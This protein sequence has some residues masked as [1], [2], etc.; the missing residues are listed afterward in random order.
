LLIFYAL[1]LMKRRALVWRASSRN[2]VRRELL[3]LP[4]IVL[5]VLISPGN[6]GAHALCQPLRDFALNALQRSGTARALRMFGRGGACLQTRK[7][8]SRTSLPMVSIHMS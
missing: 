3:L 7:H 4:A 5:N 6:Q 8:L 2:A 1:T